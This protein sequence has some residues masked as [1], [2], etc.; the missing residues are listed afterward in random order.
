MPWSC[1]FDVFVFHFAAIDPFSPEKLQIQQLTLKTQCQGHAPNRRK[2]NQVGT[3]TKNEVIS[4][5]RGKAIRFT[6]VMRVLLRTSL[7]H[8]W[9]VPQ[10]DPTLPLGSPANCYANRQTLKRFFPYRKTSCI[11]RTKSQNLNV[12][13]LVLQLS[14]LNP[15]KPGVKSRMKM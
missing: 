13:Y 8:S 9:Q 11:N 3:A 6:R 1:S 4:G 12:S 15:L 2:F 5:Y 7:M 10:T 14:L